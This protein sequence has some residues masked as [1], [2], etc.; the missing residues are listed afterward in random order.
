MLKD[1]LNIMAALTTMSNRGRWYL[2][3]RSHCQYHE[4]TAELSEDEP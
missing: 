2:R 1:K 3:W 4:K